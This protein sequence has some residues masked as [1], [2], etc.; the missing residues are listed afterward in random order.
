[1][2]APPDQPLHL[3]GCAVRLRPWDMRARRPGRRNADG[4]QKEGSAEREEGLAV[5]AFLVG[6]KPRRH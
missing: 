5:Y 2:G 3:G 1:V 6:A 4:R